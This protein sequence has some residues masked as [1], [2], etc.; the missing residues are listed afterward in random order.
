MVNQLLEP[1]VQGAEPGQNALEFPA[2]PYD[3]ALGAY[4]RQSPLPQSTL[5]STKAF[6]LT[7][8]FVHAPGRDVPYSSPGPLASL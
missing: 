1:L 2:A 4:V 7:Y 8:G 6:G 5:L 3:V